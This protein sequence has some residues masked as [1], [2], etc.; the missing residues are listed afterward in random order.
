MKPWKAS[1]END[2]TL[3]ESNTQPPCLNEMNLGM[4][5]VGRWKRVMFSRP[6]NKLILSDSNLFDIIIQSSHDIE[7]INYWKKMYTSST[8]FKLSKTLGSNSL[9]V[10][11]SKTLRMKKSL[12]G[13][14]EKYNVNFQDNQ[15]HQVLLLQ[16][17]RR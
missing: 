3:F 6:K 2:L 12:N 16:Q 8:I 13:T 7:F 1:S 17:C 14:W 4:R 15:N 5:F 9:N 10:L 11:L